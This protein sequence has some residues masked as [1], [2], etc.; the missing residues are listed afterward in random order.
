MRIQSMMEARIACLRK[1][2][3]LSGSEEWAFFCNMDLMLADGRKLGYL[4]WMGEGQ[5]LDDGLNM[6]HGWIVYGNFFNVRK[7][8]NGSL[9]GNLLAARSGSEDRMH[10]LL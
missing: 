1:K 3:I 7:E 5:M 4:L 2:R 6:G 9:H 8:K 10:T